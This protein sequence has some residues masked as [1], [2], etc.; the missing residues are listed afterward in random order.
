[1]H[2]RKSKIFFPRTTLLISFKRCTK[3]IWVNWID[4]VQMKD[5]ALI[6]GEKLR[7]SKNM[8]RK[9]KTPFQ[10]Y[11]VNFNQI[12]HEASF[13]EG[14]PGFFFT[15]WDHSIITIGTKP[16][17]MKG[18][19]VCSNEWSRPFPTGD[20]YEIAK[21]HYQSLKMFFTRTIGPISIKLCTKHPWVK[22]NQDFTNNQNEDDGFFLL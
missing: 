13:G 10:N 19:W 21:I 1:M 8:S 2:F 12:L 5:H 3:Y 17:W 9:F 15:N 16:L 18:I 4:F 20:N 6:Q 7:N 11:R 22:R 14:D